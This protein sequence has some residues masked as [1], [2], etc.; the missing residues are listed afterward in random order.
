[1]RPLG[2]EAASRQHMHGPADGLV[3]KEEADSALEHL[4]TRLQADD[5]APVLPAQNA[6]PSRRK[7]TWAS[8]GE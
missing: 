5:G 2:I 1:M 3:C 4:V 7:L 6:S 8:V